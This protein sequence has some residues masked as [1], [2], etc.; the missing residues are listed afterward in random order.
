VPETIAPL[1]ATSGGA[2]L[3]PGKSL[4]THDFEAVPVISKA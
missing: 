1:G 4:A 3:V 2:K